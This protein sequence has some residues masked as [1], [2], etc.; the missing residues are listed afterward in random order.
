[1]LRKHDWLTFQCCSLESV[2]YICVFTIRKNT[3]DTVLLKNVFGFEPLSFSRP[4]MTC[5]ECGG[6]ACFNLWMELS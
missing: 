4:L 2:V 6:F 1:M 5:I 3:A